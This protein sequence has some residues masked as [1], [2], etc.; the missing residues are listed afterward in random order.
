MKIKLPAGWT[1]TLPKNE[2]ISGPLG[3][4]ETVYSQTGRDLFLSRTISGS[5]GIL[6][7]ERI[8]EVLAWF[9]AVGSDDSKLIVLQKQ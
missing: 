8:N 6:P 2:K 5:T 9:K 7:P 3:N 1:A 4:Y